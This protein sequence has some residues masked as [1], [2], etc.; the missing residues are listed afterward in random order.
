[1]SCS[2][3]SLRDLP[4]CGLRTNRDVDRALATSKVADLVTDRDLAHL[5]EPVQ[6]YLRAAGV[7]GHPR[8]HN[9]RVR[10]LGRI[11]NG[12]EA[13]WI[14]LVA[15]QYNFVDEPARLFYLNGSMFMIPV[16]GY[17]RYVGR[18]ATMRIKAA[19]LV[20]VVDASGDEM[21]QGETVTM[22]ND[23]CVMAPA[24]LIS[25]AITWEGAGESTASA[26]FTNAG[27]TIRAELFFNQAGE[28]T[29][30]WSDDRYQ[31]SSD[32][33][34]ARKVRWSTPLGR[35]RSFGRVRLASGGEGRWHEPD[36]E[37]AYI[38]LTIDDVQYNVRSR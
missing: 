2:A 9:F 35:Y 38:E 8:V 3:F 1:M 29:N 23:M 20:A 26:S 36:G 32:G 30:F 28:L 15:E 4:A 34:G 10:M 13:R 21:N 19:A 18:S 17:H 33:K 14:P 6:R 7:V 5:P 25:P 24:T 27:H 22:F 16:Q 31:T 11:R 12:P 37:Y